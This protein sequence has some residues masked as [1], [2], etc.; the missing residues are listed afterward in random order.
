M[1]LLKSLNRHLMISLIITVVVI[2]TGH[3]VSYLIG[4]F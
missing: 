2:G 1:Q 3:I 4:Q